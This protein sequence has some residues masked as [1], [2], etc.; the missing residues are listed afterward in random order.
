MNLFRASGRDG[1]VAGGARGA[2]TQHGALRRAVDHD[3][4]VGFG[5]DV[6]GGGHEHAFDREPL[7]RHAED[8][9]RV[10]PGFG[11]IAGELHAARFAPTAGMYLGLHHHAAAEARRNRARLLGRTCH[12]ARGHRDAVAAQ[13]V[14]CLILVQIHAG[15]RVMVVHPSPPSAAKP[16]DSAA[17]TPRSPPERTNA[18]AASTVGRI[19][20]VPSSVPASRWSAP[21]KSRR[22]IARWW[23]VPW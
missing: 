18:A 23:L 10:D 14:A 22:R 16:S 3:A 7:D 9:R 13:D 19:L 11:G 6:H 2:H 4:D 5:P 8:P 21:A 1:L 17:M 15:S 20:P 12:F